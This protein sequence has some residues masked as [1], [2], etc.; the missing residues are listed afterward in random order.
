M[1]TQYDGEGKIMFYEGFLYCLSLYDSTT[2]RTIN[3]HGA[4]HLYDFI[5]KGLF[6]YTYFKLRTS[7]YEQRN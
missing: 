3:S 5:F 2:I 7:F 6:M 1:H 4:F